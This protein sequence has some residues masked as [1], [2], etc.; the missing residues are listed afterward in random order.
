[1][2]RVGRGEDHALAVR[3]QLGRELRARRGL[4]RAVHAE[5]QEHARLVREIE[6]AR[7][8]RERLD[9]EAAEERTQLIGP[10]DRAEHLLLFRAMLEVGGIRGTEVRRDQDLL[11]LLEER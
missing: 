3:L 1:A 11:E 5:H 8:R 7:L 9:E 10:R 2:K 6:R 4:A